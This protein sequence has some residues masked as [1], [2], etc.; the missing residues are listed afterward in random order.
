M[1]GVIRAVDRLNEIVTRLLY[2]SRADSSDRRPIQ[3][4][5]ILTETIESMESQADSQGVVLE[6]NLEP[7][8]PT[9][10]GSESGLRQVC[11]HLATN[12]MQAMPEGGRLRCHSCYQA[13]EHTVE[14]RFIDTGSGVSREDRQHLFEPFF[15]TRPG[16]TGLG[17]A[18]CREIVTQHA[19]RIELEPSE[20]SGATFRVRLPATP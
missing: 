4:N 10:L 5:L 14:L 20:G 3:I 8:L 12:A 16:G 11:L 17:L 13:Q 19:G 7:E 6:L 1:D 18:L 9:V 2:F 15:T